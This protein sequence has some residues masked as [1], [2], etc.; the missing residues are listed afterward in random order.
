[1]HW[2]AVHIAGPLR[3]LKDRGEA[4]LGQA[5]TAVSWALVLTLQAMC[6]A[7]PRGQQSRRGHRRARRRA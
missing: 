4:P 7:E 6:L 5:L 1:M 2:Q 3:A